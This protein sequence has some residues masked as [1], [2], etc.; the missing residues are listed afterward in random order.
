MGGVHI[1]TITSGERS[2]TSQ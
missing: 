1:L 2:S